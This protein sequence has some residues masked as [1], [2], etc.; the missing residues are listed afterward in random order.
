VL[1]TTSSN[2]YAKYTTLDFTILSTLQY[3]RIYE[4][5]SKMP[6]KKNI[7]VAF[8]EPWATRVME[9]TV[10]CYVYKLGLKVI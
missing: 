7:S 10:G 9:D 5:I 6:I 4:V 1:A 8:F 2:E 3:T